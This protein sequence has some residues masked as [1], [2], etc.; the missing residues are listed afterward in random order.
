MADSP[1]SAAAP[2]T[3]A[4]SGPRQAV[5]RLSARTPLRVKL[6]T[7]L[8]ALVIAALACIS[9]AGIFVFR[10]YL[11]NKTDHELTGLF[12]LREDYAEPPARPAHRQL[13]RSVRRG[14]RADR[15]SSCASQPGTP[16]TSLPRVPLSTAWLNANAGRLV[17]VP[18][19]AGDGAWRVFTEQVQ[20]IDPNTGA[21]IT[22]TLVVGANLGDINQ[23]IGQAG[24]HRPDRRR[25]LSCSSWPSS[26]W[27]WSGPACGRWPRSS[28]RPARSPPGTSAGASP[29]AIRAPRS[30][31][32][33]GRS[34][35][36]SPTS[37]P[38]SAPRPS[39]RRPPASPRAGC[40]SSR[41]MPATSCA[42]R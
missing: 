7:A 27:P 41:P 33:A 13:G 3:S 12:E 38:R 8:L 32:S 42:R 10:S 34:T 30:A 35:S 40:G 6:I 1:T 20:Y 9:I 39:P 31:A 5:S 24:Q 15:S 14:L 22:G 21:V 11:L 26:A 18:A 37:R 16:A 2:P 17:T 36:C 25:R 19:L 23:T 4:G 28:R 29:T